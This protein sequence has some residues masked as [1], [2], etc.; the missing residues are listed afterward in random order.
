MEKPNP[1]TTGPESTGVDGPSGTRA[2]A[3]GDSSA[4]DVP[5]DAD[6]AA[7]VRETSPPPPAP[8]KAAAEETFVGAS[9]TPVPGKP[10]LSD[11]FPRKNQLQPGDVLGGRFEILQVL[12]ESGMG[13]V[14]KAV[15]REVD[16]VVALKLI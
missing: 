14:Y 11:I 10:R 8:R 7:F 2:P 5:R 12:G 4:S 6:G 1:N 16:H 3:K 9:R 15:D 13:T